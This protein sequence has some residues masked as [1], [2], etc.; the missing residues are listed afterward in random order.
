M[1]KIWSRIWQSGWGY[2]LVQTFLNKLSS[3]YHFYSVKKHLIEFGVKS[4]ADR[5]GDGNTDW[6][7]LP[8]QRQGFQYFVLH[9]PRVWLFLF[10]GIVTLAKTLAFYEYKWYK[11]FIFR[12]MMGTL[13]FSELWLHPP[14]CKTTNRSQS[15]THSS[16]CLSPAKPSFQWRN[17]TISLY[18]YVIRADL[19]TQEPIPP[20][21]PPPNRHRRLY[22]HSP[23]PPTRHHRLCFLLKPRVL[24][25]W[26]Y[27]FQSH[28]SL[29]ILPSHVR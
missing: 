9:Y 8:C 4:L 21:F 10:I 7:I 15:L 1:G 5:V 16:A 3:S 18:T 13:K 17:N 28:Y 20:P 27:L 6:E 12:M 2:G 19:P 24:F 29:L 14:I 22:F 25:S 26:R 23:P 11:F